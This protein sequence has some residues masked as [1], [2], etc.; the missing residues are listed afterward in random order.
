MSRKTTEI[1]LG[2]EA[3]R[4]ADKVFLITEMV[5]TQSEAWAF[6][7][8][9]AMSRSGSKVDVA[10]GWATIASTG[11]QA[12][13]AAP[14]DEL[15]PLLDEMMNC[16]QRVMPAATRKLIEDDTEEITTRLRLRN[17]VLTLHMGF[18]P[19][20]ALFQAVAALSTPETQISSNTQTS[21]EESVSQ[22]QAD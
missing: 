13:F 14:Y 4:D 7:A 8:L 18:S 3:D 21:E 2:E 5:A 22:S 17:E 12:L 9:S 19:A 10:G 16:V 20:A 1:T 6:R 11:L 15:K